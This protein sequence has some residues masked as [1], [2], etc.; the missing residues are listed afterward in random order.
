MPHGFDHVTYD[1]HVPE[2]Q[3]AYSEY[4]KLINES[5]F[6]L[7]DG[8]HKSAAATLTRNPIYALELQSDED[9]AKIR[10]MIE[11]GELFDFKR[12]E[13]SLKNLV[14]SFEEYA[15]GEE[16]QLSPNDV[17]QIRTVQQRI[18]ELT[19]NGD[20]PQYM[21]ERYLSGTQAR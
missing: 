19:S 13:T 4:S 11:R 8:N 5:R 1:Q 10:K 16:S 15:L 21:K 14:I 17:E 3:E 7:L 6:Y 12:R 2:W 9:I 18:D 20:L